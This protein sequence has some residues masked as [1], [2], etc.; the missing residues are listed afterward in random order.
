VLLAEVC[1]Y[2][3]WSMDWRD[4]DADAHL[5]DGPAH[6]VSGICADALAALIRAIR[7]WAP[8]TPDGDAVCT[9]DQAAE[10]TFEPLRLEFR[11]TNEEFAN[12]YLPWV[13]TAFIILERDHA[14]VETLVHDMRKDGEDG[15]AAIIEIGDNIETASQ[16]FSALGELLQTAHMRLLAGC[17]R[18]AL[19]RGIGND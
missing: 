3:L 14:G 5:A 10:L 18:E 15:E 16:K 17:A 13:R 11:E 8:R 4:P 6:Q 1:F 12:L 2:T 9:V 7:D 19:A